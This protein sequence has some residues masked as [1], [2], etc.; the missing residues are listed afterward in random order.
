MRAYV[1][2]KHLLDC[3]LFWLL[4]RLV[5]DRQRSHFA[6]G[7]NGRELLA[8]LRLHEALVGV[9]IRQ[10]GML[11]DLCYYLA[12]CL[13]LFFGE[14]LLWRYF[15]WFLR[16]WFS[17]RSDFFGL[18]NRFYRSFLLRFGDGSRALLRLWG[19][20]LAWSWFGFRWRI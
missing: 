10:R 6:L 18:L 2:R 14:R 4:V 11:A 1:A 8:N 9:M 5:V 7:Y 12:L 17:M 15:D 20:L 19:L 3:A 13:S 16:Q